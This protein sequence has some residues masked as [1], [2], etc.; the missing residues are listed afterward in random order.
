M[1]IYT[2]K[3]NKHILIFLKYSGEATNG[4]EYAFAKQK[5]T[6]LWTS[7]PLPTSTSETEKSN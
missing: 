5:W 4:E 3:W 7:P 2:K 1:Q 6:F